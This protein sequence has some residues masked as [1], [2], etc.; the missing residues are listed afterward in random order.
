MLAL[1]SAVPPLASSAPIVAAA[2]N[3]DGVLV[4]RG[5]ARRAKVDIPDDGGKKQKC[6]I[7]DRPQIG[8][9]QGRRSPLE[10]KAQNGGIEEC[11]GGQ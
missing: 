2:N 1:L 7:D 3:N 11:V 8:G 5:T 6:K 4:L 9:S 10:Q